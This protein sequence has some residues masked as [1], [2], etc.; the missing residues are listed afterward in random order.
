MPLPLG[1]HFSS[2][3]V[4]TVADRHKHWLMFYRQLEHLLVLLE[5]FFL[6]HHDHR[7]ESLLPKSFCDEHSHEEFLSFWLF[8]AD[9]L[10]ESIHIHP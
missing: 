5:T 10:K 7:E 2:V 3:Q 9:E 1:I 8:P 4:T 6:I